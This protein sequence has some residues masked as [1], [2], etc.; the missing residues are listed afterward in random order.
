MTDSPMTDSSAPDSW[1][2][3]P[4]TI[5]AIAAMPDGGQRNKLITETYY[6]LAVAIGDVTDPTSANWFHFGVWASQSVGTIMRGE[7]LPAWLR[8]ALVGN[9]DMLGGGEHR[10]ALFDAMEEAAARVSGG[11][12]AGNLKVFREMAPAGAAF[13]ATRTGSDEARAT[14]AVRLREYV[15]AAPS[16]RATNCFGAGFTA[17]AAAA[18]EADADCRAQHVLGSALQLGAAEQSQLDPIL[19]SLMCSVPEEFIGSLERR[20][21]IPMLRRMARVIDRAWD[22]EV[23]RRFMVLVLPFETLKLG[24]DVPPLPGSGL[25]PSCTSVVRAPSLRQALETWDRTKGTGRGDAA[26][27]WS[28]LD[29]RMDWVSWFFRS[30]FRD[31]RLQVAPFRES[32]A[33]AL[34]RLLGGETQS[35]QRVL[36]V[37][38][39]TSS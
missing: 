27:D 37:R 13:V 33:A 31:E 38:G 36:G 1:W 35:F 19:D 34:R 39:R 3:K 20:F 18:T 25:V 23:T 14:A 30:R 17:L 10:F 7:M 4:A 29:D 12:A 24:H 8:R 32:E 5:A 21:R 26:R 9:G 28:V 11:L 6:R 15:A 2:L 16:V 22:K